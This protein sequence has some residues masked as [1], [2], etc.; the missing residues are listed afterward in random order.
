MSKIGKQPVQI[1]T[2]VQVKLDG[3]L[4]VVKGAK[5]EL[6]KKFPIDYLKLEIN[7]GKV[8][9][10]FLQDSIQARALWGTWRMLVANLIEGVS[11]G[12][13]KK[14]ELEGVGF[15]ASVQG[16]NLGMSLGFSH[17]V[18][19]VAPVGIEFKVEKNVITV[20]GIDKE[21]VGQTAANIRDW[22][23]PEPYKGKGIRYQ[24]EVVRRKAGK[25]VGATTS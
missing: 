15:K 9:I 24:G 22:Y 23:P 10:S 17:P 21:L 20:S 6:K 13:E 7:D 19:V 14:L 3:D 18:T 25:K 2:G 16:K 1:P 8:V 12:F 4:V 11:K 5:G